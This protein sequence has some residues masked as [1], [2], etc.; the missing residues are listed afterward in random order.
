MPVNSL[1]KADGVKVVPAAT[2]TKTNQTNAQPAPTDKKT[3]EAKPRILTWT[4]IPKQ[5]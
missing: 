3:P 4:F 1:S 2:A 5:S